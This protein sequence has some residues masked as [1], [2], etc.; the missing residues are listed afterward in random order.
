MMDEAEIQAS[1][2]AFKPFR[3]IIAEIKIRYRA[4]ASFF[5]AS[6]ASWLIRFAPQPAEHHHYHESEGGFGFAERVVPPRFELS[7]FFSD[8]S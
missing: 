3:H 1:I 7:P 8:V 2:E 5:A 6:T 4:L